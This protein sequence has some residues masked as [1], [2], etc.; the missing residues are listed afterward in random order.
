[1]S[2]IISVSTE[3]L[4]AHASK[5]T[6]KR[7]LA[8]IRS[9]APVYPMV[10]VFVI[11]VIGPWI[12]PLSPTS[13]AGSP[14]LRPGGTFHFGTDST[15]LD[16]FSRTIAAFR[17]DIVIATLTSLVSTTVGILLGLVVGMNES[18]RGL[19]GWVAR[20]LVRALDLIQ[21]VPAVVIALALVAVVGTSVFSMTVALGII[22]TPN[23]ARMVRTEVLKVRTDA[24]IDAARMAGERE[25]TLTLRHVLPNASWPA[26]E[27]ASLVFG[28]AILITATLG[29]LGV[30]LHPPTPEWGS[31]ISTG[32]SDAA[33]GRW[34]SFV[35]PAV[36]LVV[37]VGSFA[38]AGQRIFGRRSG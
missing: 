6:V 18:R 1:M 38:L 34:W 17:N 11:A 32:A 27:N 24:Y 31:M 25:F 22:L 2:V 20:F 13:V 36:A 10:A 33:V 30:G 4:T 9:M 21:A 12:V 15:G 26:L 19:L 7:I 3:T 28:A 35:F 5:A 23:Q 16:V 8:A 14:N 37:A 29:F